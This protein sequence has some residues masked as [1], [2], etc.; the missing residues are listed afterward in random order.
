MALK[1]MC[2]ENGVIIGAKTASSFFPV[3]PSP[4]PVK[5]GFSHK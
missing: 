1:L 5:K 3:L 2:I 4:P